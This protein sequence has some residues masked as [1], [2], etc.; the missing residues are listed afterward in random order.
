[1]KRRRGGGR[2]EGREGER[3]G[4]KEKGNERVKKKKRR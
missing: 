4:R 2:D 3:K 1:M